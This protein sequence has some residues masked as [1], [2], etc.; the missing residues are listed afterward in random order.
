MKKVICV[1]DDSVRPNIFI[2]SIVGNKSFGDVILKRQNIKSKF[3]TFLKN[4][5]LPYEVILLSSAWELEPFLQKIRTYQAEYGV[6]HIFSN[7]IVRDKE[8]ASY[9][10][11]KAPYVHRPT[12]S[13]QADRPVLFIFETVSEYARF[14]ERNFQNL[15]SSGIFTGFDIAETNAFFDI[16]IHA[17][18]LQYISG[19]FDSRFFNSVQGDEFTVT[20][21]S[22]DIH[23]IQ[24]EYQ[25]YHLLPDEMKMWF[26][27][28]YHFEQKGNR[29]SYQMERFHMTD[30]AIRYAH[31]AIDLQEFEQLLHK[32]FYFI[33]SRKEKEISV[34]QAKM[35]ADALYL[36]KVDERIEKLKKCEKYA[37]LAVFLEAGAFTGGIDAIVDRYKYLYQIL[38]SRR[39]TEKPISV[40]G[41]G[42]LCFSNML[43]NKE[44]NLL[45][46][47]DP[48]GATE[49]SQLWTDPY[50]DVAKLSH[51]VCGK[52]DF[53]N[54]ALYH[55]SLDGDLN[56][57]LE[58][59][60]DNND[61]IKLFQN[62]CEE[63]G[64]DYILVR[65]YEASL[66]LSM[67]PMHMDNPL[68]VF[69]FILNAIKIL[70]EVEKCLKE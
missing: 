38:S 46:L 65:L 26:V 53:F 42:D 62:F 64:F 51:S 39:T 30:L 29:A 25:F 15:M 58:I 7:Q 36:Y 50:Y 1:Y 18:F 2:Q 41:H 33:N 66:F 20:K 60:F 3:L 43:F 48:K 32:V 6:I 4:S 59:P 13:I 34:E 23:K 68:K 57:E 61:Y 19:G 54:N 56:F 37:N 5:N 16:S 11:K 40:I 17:N 63:Y 35:N 31:G 10:M 67:L 27:M 28:P 22:T 12:L 69:G 49:E 24:A 21:S 47:I 8:K 45:K 70:D 14:I 44:A 9:L 52:Y 55:I